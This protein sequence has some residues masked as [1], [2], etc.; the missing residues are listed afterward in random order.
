MQFVY[1]VWGSQ[2]EY[3]DRSDWNVA[4]YYLEE[5]AKQHAQLAKE[6][7]DNAPKERYSEKYRQY[8]K[9]SPY[10]VVAVWDPDCSYYVVKIPLVAHVDEFIESP[11]E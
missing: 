6:Y 5:A 1:L 2:G 10:D 9:S 11:K 4:A 3:S 7:I 8:V